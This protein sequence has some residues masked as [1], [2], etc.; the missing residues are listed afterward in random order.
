MTI[1]ASEKSERITDVIEL[2]TEISSRRPRSQ[3]EVRDARIAATKSVAQRK[4]INEESVRDKCWR[5]LDFKV[6]DQFDSMV[7][8]W[9]V[10][11]KDDLV[12]RLKSCASQRNREGDLQ[13]IQTFFDRRNVTGP[14]WWWVNQN[15][16]FRQERQGGYIWAP[17][18]TKSGGEAF[19]HANVS[20]VKAG[21]II[22]HY[23]NQQLVAI[24]VA[25]T[26][27]FEQ[28]KPSELE[29]DEWGTEGYM[30]SV[31][32]FDLVD[33][34][35]RDVIPLEL[36]TPLSAERKSPFNRGGTVNQG[37]L[38]RLSDRFV[39]A[40]ITK[41][42]QLIP[43]GVDLE[44]I[45]ENVSPSEDNETAYRELSEKIKN[46][47]VNRDFGTIKR[48]KPAV[49]L[50]ALELIDHINKNEIPFDTLLP[51]FR[52]VTQRYGIKSGITQAE[53]AFF[54]L[55]K[56]G[57]WDFVPI[58][59]EL[60]KGLEPAKLR[61][62]VKHVKFL[63]RYWDV[64]SDDDYRAKL[65]NDLIQSW[66]ADDGVSDNSLNT[67]PFDR[68]AALR[69]LVA[70]ILSDG[71][72]FE[73]WQI[74]AYVTAIRTK[75]FVILGGISGSGKSQLPQLVAEITGGEKKLIPVRPDWTDS[76]DVIGYV[77][78]QGQPNPG[79]FLRFAADA[80]NEPN[81]S[82]CAIIDEMNV[83]RVEHYFAEVLSL[84]E[85][86][87]ANEGNVH[88]LFD[89][90][91]EDEEHSK[92][93]RVGLPSNLAI[94][95]TVNMDETTHGFS[96]KVLDR[97]FTLEFSEIN[98]G[99]WDAKQREAEY[100]S[101]AWPISAWQPRA[102][103]LCELLD[104][105]QAE[106]DLVSTTINSLVSLNDILG[107]AQLQ[108]AYRS[109]D[110]IAMFVLH[111]SD[112]LDSF[113]DSSGTAVDPLDLAIQMKVLPRIAGGSSVIESVL[114]ELLGWAYDGRIDQTEGETD[115]LIKRWLKQRKPH[116]L[117]E[118][119]FPRTCARLCLMWHRLDKDRFTSYWL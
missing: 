95:G 78:L 108:L 89:H 114:R 80:T 105:T 71:Y 64:I 14:R 57:I 55:D 104:L 16:T 47:N 83:A 110:E 111:A 30:V 63:Q 62:L 92:W 43:D 42:P 6:I 19:H 12:E 33:P 38:F 28:P 103:R 61:R 73:P 4:G 53:E 112:V 79:K 52:E 91:F 98:I 51:V 34:I 109:R 60:A 87:R 41:F 29:S 36:R 40:L 76:S 21:D 113:V 50:A 5:Q 44:N 119:I 93:T 39:Q 31:K 22:W 118:A 10:N 99:K 46:L 2:L 58:S 37:Y 84:L 56:D 96:K 11:G 54:R 66:F 68:A 75:P 107:Q 101:K 24:S 67:E 85:Q 102:R 1:G 17:Q 74:A 7:Y 20:S 8:D 13:A 94:V 70:D 3:E 27:A 106:R 116:S 35:P 65:K 117:K 100:Q 25:K 82:W 15:K 32:Y 81:L 72:Y 90:H 26:D 77:Q 49:V 18:K 115:D 86:S 48:Y 69:Q 97:A 23:C 88:P 9:I 45:F 59:G